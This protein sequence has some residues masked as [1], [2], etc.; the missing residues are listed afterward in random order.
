MRVRLPAIPGDFMLDLVTE[1]SCNTTN[2]SI[3][4]K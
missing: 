2:L 4:G 1:E 3:Y